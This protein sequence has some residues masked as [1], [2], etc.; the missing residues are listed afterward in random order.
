MKEQ[1]KDTESKPVKDQKNP[2]EWA[3]FGISLLTILAIFVYLIYQTLNYKPSSPE[4]FVE[5]WPDPTEAQPHRY[6]VVVQNT[7]G[8]TAES[9]QVELRLEQANQETEKATLELP[10]VPQESR[11]EGWVNFSSKPVHE[12]AVTGKVVSYQ[13]P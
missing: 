10:Y 1:A 9:V 3:V 7:G 11:R 5:Y 4:L 13:K 8:E 2:L 12:K 6:H